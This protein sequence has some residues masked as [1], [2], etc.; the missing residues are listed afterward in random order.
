MK[1]NQFENINQ[2]LYVENNKKLTMINSKLCFQYVK[3]GCKFI[4]KFSLLNQYY[5]TLLQLS[6]LQYSQ[7][8]IVLIRL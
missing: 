4:V 6:A 1:K 3:G 7:L 2:P 8:K 5:L